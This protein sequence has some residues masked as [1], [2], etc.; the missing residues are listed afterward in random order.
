MD[1]RPRR[2]VLNLAGMYRA[3]TIA[4]RARTTLHR[5]LFRERLG[6][7]AGERSVTDWLVE[8]ANVRGYFGAT[9]LEVPDRGVTPGL[10]DEE[11]ERV[12]A[13]QPFPPRGYRP[14]PIRYD[15]RRLIARPATRES[16]WR[17]ARR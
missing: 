17:A 2:R 3:P 8:E 4:E 16:T 9:T 5:S 15:P 14:L 11:L 7:L 10:T 6:R 13:A 12:I 1:W